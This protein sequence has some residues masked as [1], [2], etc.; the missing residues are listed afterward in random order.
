MADSATCPLGVG[1]PLWRPPAER[2]KGV[3]VNGRARGPDP[4]SSSWI[5]MKTSLFWDEWKGDFRQG[6]VGRFGRAGLARLDMGGPA[7]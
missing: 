5:A 7:M 3:D 4:V 1:T 2:R 6:R